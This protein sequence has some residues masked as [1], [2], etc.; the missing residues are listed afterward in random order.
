[1]IDNGSCLDFIEI[2]F[3]AF[4]FS[5]SANDAGQEGIFSVFRLHNVCLFN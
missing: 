1:M 2:C 3:V 5:K 4:N